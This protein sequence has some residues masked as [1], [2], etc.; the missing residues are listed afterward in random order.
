MEQIAAYM[1]LDGRIFANKNDCQE[2][3][4]IYNLKTGLRLLFESAFSL[5]GLCLEDINNVVG[6]V[7]THR[8]EVYKLLDEAK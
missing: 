2:S 8:E 5:D 3:D 6:L 7:L 4:K 1:S